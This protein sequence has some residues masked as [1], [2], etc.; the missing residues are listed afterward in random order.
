HFTDVEIDRGKF[1]FPLKKI[2]LNADTRTKNAFI[3]LKSEVADIYINGEFNLSNLPGSFQYILNHYLP[4]YIAEVKKPY[5]QNFKYT[6]DLKQ[7]KIIT[8]L[9]YPRMQ[10]GKTHVTGGVN[11]ET[12][13]IDINLNS[14]YFYWDSIKFTTIYIATSNDIKNDLIHINQTLGSFSLNDS[15]SFKNIT[16]NGDIKNDSFQYKMVSY[17][18]RQ[19]YDFDWRG[20]AVLKGDSVK[21]VWDQSRIQIYRKNY[22]IAANSAITFKINQLV[23]DQFILSNEQE[24]ILANGVVGKKKTDALSL[25]IENFDIGFLNGFI[26]TID[27]G[28]HGNASGDLTIKSALG[29]PLFIANVFSENSIAGVDTLGDLQLATTFDESTNSVKMEAR[30]ISGNLI[31]VEA[32]GDIDLTKGTQLNIDIKVPKTPIKKFDYYTKFLI[33]NLEGTLNADLKLKGTPQKPLV[34]GRVYFDDARFTVDYIKTRYSFNQYFDLYENY[35]DLNKFYLF[36]EFGKTALVSG[37]VYHKSY[38]NYRLDVHVDNCKSFHCLNTSKKDNALYYG[39]AF[40]SGKAYFYGTMDDIGMDITAKS[41]KGTVIYIPLGSPEEA[42]NVDFIKF[43]SRDSSGVKIN[44]NQSADLS[45][46]RMN[47]NFEI[48]PVAEI[49]LIFDEALGDIMKGN[50]SGNLRMEIDT[51]RNFNMYGQYTIEKGEYLF[52]ALNVFQKKF[53][54]KSGGTI[55][56]DGAP[57]DAKMNLSAYYRVRTSPD[58]LLGTTSGTNPKLT[59]DCNLFLKGKL[60]SPD[61]KF[62][63]TFPEIENQN[64]D[65]NTILNTIIKQVENDQEE[66]NRQIF[67]LMMLKQ[68]LPRQG[69]SSGYSVGSISQGSL[70]ATVSDLISA[71]M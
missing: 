49:Q 35:I 13:N 46:L 29:S 59:V 21:M 28:I 25:K 57:L 3:Q 30:I 17:E 8:D 31:G 9:F 54:V 42:N 67:S 56:W 60:F 68:F 65:N 66:L 20:Y 36:D 32:K 40:A 33:S 15:V 37:K 11:S 38:D 19:K 62:G 51:R 2:E 24:N 61:I 63:L 58:P 6:I 12:N 4:N 22:T 1:H 41:E 34:T 39:K 10:V 27:G 5:K 16:L 55:N 64:S 53:Y 26:K 43:I 70:T 23:F 44:Q 52:T 18:P 50:G 48:T 69:T 47:F 14:S 45:G 71:Q 7:T